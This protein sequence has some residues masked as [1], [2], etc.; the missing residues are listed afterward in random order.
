MMWKPRTGRTKEEFYTQINSK[1]KFFLNS[2]TNYKFQMVTDD[3]DN[4]RDYKK[5]TEDLFFL[6]GSA[7]IK[8]LHNKRIMLSQEQGIYNAP[9]YLLDR[10]IIL[11][12]SDEKKLDTL[13]NEIFE[14]LERIPNVVIVVNPVNKAFKY[15]DMIY[16]FNLDDEMTREVFFKN[17][18][19]FLEDRARKLNINFPEKTISEDLPHKRRICGIC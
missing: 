8:D 10:C 13:L 16:K 11:C 17:L 6:C 15:D 12:M 3:P 14:N 2:E 9:P 4:N 7:F 19:N 18:V 5:L 1:L